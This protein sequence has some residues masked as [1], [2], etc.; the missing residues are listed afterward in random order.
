[1]KIRRLQITMEPV[2]HYAEGRPGFR[3][4]CVEVRTDCGKIFF[5]TDVIH[6]DDF[7]DEFRRLMLDAEFRIRKLIQEKNT[8]ADK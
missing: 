1:M 5:S 2:C 7:V 6:E 8:P 4:V 3:T